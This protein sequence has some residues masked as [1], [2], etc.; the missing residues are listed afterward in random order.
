MKFQE[1]KARQ[2]KLDRPER[3]DRP[4]RLER[5]ELPP[6]ASAAGPIGQPPIPMQSSNLVTIGGSQPPPSL[7]H[8]GFMQPYGRP[9]SPRS[10]DRP[11]QPQ[12]LQQQVDDLISKVVT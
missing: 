9:H 11:P 10:L 12:H 6:M 4:D 3:L 5:S 1:E 7:G 8:F 2:E